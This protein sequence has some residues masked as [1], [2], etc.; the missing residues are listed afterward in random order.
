MVRSHGERAGLVIQVSLPL[1]DAEL[2]AHGPLMI[3]SGTISP[4]TVDDLQRGEPVV[5]SSV[6]QLEVVL[7]GCLVIAGTTAA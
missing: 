3:C 1:V 7:V 6:P 5:S 2:S 4:W